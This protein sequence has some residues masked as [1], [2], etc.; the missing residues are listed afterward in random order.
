[1]EPEPDAQL[2]PPATWR[3][4]RSSTGS[5]EEIEAALEALVADRDADASARETAQSYLE[6]DDP[7]LRAL[8]K[9]LVQYACSIP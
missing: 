5:D 1:M 6:E 3:G 8:Q 7:T 9:D 2:P 4:R